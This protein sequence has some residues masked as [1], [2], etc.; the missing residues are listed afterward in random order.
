[1]TRISVIVDEVYRLKRV[2]HDK[3]TKL[4]PYLGES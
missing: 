2:M 4:S 3:I 1:M